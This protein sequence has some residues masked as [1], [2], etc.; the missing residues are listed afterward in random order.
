MFV[1]WPGDDDVNGWTENME[2]ASGI[3]LCK[4]RAS[5]VSGSSFFWADILAIRTCGL[6][7][8]QL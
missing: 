4:H 5:L 3:G 6:L 7:K 2:G 1:V 8:F